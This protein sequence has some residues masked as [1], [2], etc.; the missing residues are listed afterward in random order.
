[1][2]TLAFSMDLKVT[3]NIKYKVLDIKKNKRLFYDKYLSRFHTGC[4]ANMGDDSAKFLDVEFRAPALVQPFI[5]LKNATL[6]SLRS[7]QLKELDD[8]ILQI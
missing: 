1:M 7:T 3:T 4:Q 6:P 2:T 8:N 5:D